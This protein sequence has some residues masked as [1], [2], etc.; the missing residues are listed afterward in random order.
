MEQTWFYLISI[1]SILSLLLLRLLQQKP[2][3]P[4]IT[5]PS[6]PPLPI[7]GHLH[8]IKQPLHRT[9]EKLSQQY[10]PIFTLRFGSRPVLILSSPSA[11]EELFSKNDLI[12]ANRPR[13]L[14][15]K[16]IHYNYT[17]IGSSS[18]GE[19]WRDLRRLTTLEIFSTT[20]LNLFLGI[21]QEEVRSLLRNLF[22]S[23]RK[24]FVKIE[25]K[26]R[27]STMLYNTIMRILSGKRYY[28]IDEEDSEE[29]G[30]FRDIIRNVSEL[31]GALHLGDFVPSLRWVDFGKLEKRM[32][33]TKKKM[34]AIFQGLIDE[35]R[36][37]DTEVSHSNGGKA[38]SMI[39]SM[40]GLQNS[41]PQYYSDEIIKGTILTNRISPNC[42]TSS[43][44][45]CTIGGFQVER[46]TML[47]VNAWGIHRDPKVWEDPTSF[48]PERFEG[49]EIEAYK[50]LPF[51]I[52]RRS[53]PGM[54]L[55][56]RVVGLALATL[57]QCFEWERISEELVDM[58]E[59][60]GVVISKAKPLEA[61]CRARERMVNVLSEL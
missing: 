28:G 10:G 20:K 45:D 44:D 14:A 56:N 16:H 53:C 9:L 11:I 7:I 57:I 25:M 42:P 30:E 13:R 3:S 29:A 24:S 8:L 17:T 27:I 6:P 21:R 61:M 51:G 23:S 26:S 4:K 35:N 18:Y 32:L 39:N 52:G 1:A 2:S 37:E 60:Q 15:G 50:L 12:F 49:V 31:S 59:G 40:L 22:R 34:D 54:G 58:C 55:A 33:T 38:K 19:H 47:F 48:R 46:G 41:D 43:S 36:S 5:P